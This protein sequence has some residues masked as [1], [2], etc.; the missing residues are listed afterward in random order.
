MKELLPKYTIHIL[1]IRAIDEQTFDI[2]AKCN[3]II[4]CADVE[5]ECINEN[6]VA[7]ILKIPFEDVTECTFPGAFNDEHA[8][9][10]AEFVK[11]LPEEVS[12]IYACC[13]YGR[14]RSA[15][16]AAALLKASGRDVKAVWG[17]PYYTPNELVYSRLCGAFGVECTDEEIQTLIDVSENAWKKAQRTGDTGGHELWE[18]LY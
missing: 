18:L 2:A 11:N 10:I 16:V 7:N 6:N 15:A 9:A 14:S 4:V 13:E 1:A 3:A 17:S 5:N 12:D 8:S